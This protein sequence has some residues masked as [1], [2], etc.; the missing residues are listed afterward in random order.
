MRERER[1]TNIE[2]ERLNSI[3]NNDYAVYA[4]K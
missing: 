3:Q 4:W 1:D 2:N